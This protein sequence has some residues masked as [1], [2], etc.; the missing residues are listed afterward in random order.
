LYDNIKINL[1][2]L[3]CENV[4]WIH[5]AQDRVQWLALVNIVM[6]FQVTYK[7]GNI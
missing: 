3:G 6:K 1:K 7:A 5:M 2:E 4:N